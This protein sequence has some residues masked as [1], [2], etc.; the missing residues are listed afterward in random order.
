MDAGT[1]TSFYHDGTVPM[2]DYQAPGHGDRPVPIGDMLL[3]P[4]KEIEG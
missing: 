3:R 2:S 4:Q 1:P